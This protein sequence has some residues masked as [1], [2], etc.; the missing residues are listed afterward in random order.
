MVVHIDTVVFQLEDGFLHELELTKTLEC[1]LSNDKHGYY[2]NND[3]Y[4]VYAYGDTMG[5]TLIMFNDILWEFYELLNIDEDEQL[6]EASVDLKRKYNELFGI[7][8]TCIG[9]NEEG[10]ISKITGYMAGEKKDN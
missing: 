8:I 7:D 3:E 2:L 9:F 4:C 10:K 6:S 1:E 5:E